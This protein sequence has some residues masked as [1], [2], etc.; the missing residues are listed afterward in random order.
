M[1]GVFILLTW[2][3]SVIYPN[4]DKVLSIMGGLCAATLDYAIPTFCYVVLSEQKWY[5]PKNLAAIIFFGRLCMVGY[6]SVILTIWEMI[7]GCKTH[8]E[9]LAGLC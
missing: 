3:I 7:T 5:H 9:F 4:I 8:K 1:T 6:G 2:V